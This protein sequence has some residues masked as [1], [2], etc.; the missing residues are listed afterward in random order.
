MIY[1]KKWPK[2]HSVKLVSGYL[3]NHS[4]CPATTGPG[5]KNHAGKHQ[6]Q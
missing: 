3:I 4:S 2:Q 1:I 6:C 5:E